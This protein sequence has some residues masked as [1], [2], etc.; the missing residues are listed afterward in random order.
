MLQRILFISIVVTALWEI[1]L[2]FFLVKFL[3]VDAHDILLVRDR[4]DPGHFQ[5]RRLFWGHEL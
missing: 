3:S 1:K 5:F 4:S 2:L